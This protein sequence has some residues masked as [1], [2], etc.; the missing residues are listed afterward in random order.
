M[1]ALIQPKKMER[2]CLGTALSPSV[3]VSCLLAGENQSYLFCH[4]SQELKITVIYI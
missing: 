3:C 4:C 1:E 2:K